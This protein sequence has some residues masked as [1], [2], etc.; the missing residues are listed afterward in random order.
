LANTKQYYVFTTTWN[1]S[2]SK[3]TMFNQKKQLR[4]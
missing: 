2:I 4:K 1:R 3:N